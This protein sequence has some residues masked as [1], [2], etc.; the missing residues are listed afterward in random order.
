LTTSAQHVDTAEG[1]ALIRKAL[2]KAFPKTQFSVRISRYSMGSS[3]DVR[4]TNGPSQRLVG[5][6]LAPFETKHFDGIDDSTRFTSCWLTYGDEVRGAKPIE[7]L[8]REIYFSFYLHTTR[9]WS[10]G[11][12]Q[13]LF[14]QVGRFY[15]VRPPMVQEY[16]PDRWELAAGFDGHRMIGHGK[17]D[18][19]DESWF[20]AVR[21][22]AD[23][24]TRY[25]VAP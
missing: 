16:E 23:D 9:N 10:P 8:S 22:A 12:A 19:P 15:G 4:W 25:E 14:A 6:V 17:I 13:K 20:Q 2:K 24:R 11:F 21:R 7:G 3:V 1:A 18:V 5:A